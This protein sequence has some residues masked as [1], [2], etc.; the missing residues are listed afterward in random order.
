MLLCLLLPVAPVDARE[1]QVP[2]GEGSLQAAID[3]ASDGDTLRL[4]VGTYS[5]SIDVNRSLILMGSRDGTSLV[6]GEGTGHAILVTAPDVVISGLD[7][8]HSGDVAEDENSGVFITD[9]GDRTL[10]ENNHLEGNLIG[11]YLKG[12]ENAWCATTA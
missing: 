4:A 10:I 6:D 1:W 8:R 2:P 5:G 9:R 11:V 7:I 12:P 3:A